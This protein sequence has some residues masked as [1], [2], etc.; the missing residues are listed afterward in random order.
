MSKYSNKQNTPLKTKKF[1]DARDRGDYS[2]KRSTMPARQ[3]DGQ[4]YAG[5][6]RLRKAMKRLGAR[7]N[8]FAGMRD[9][10]G[11]TKPGSMK[12]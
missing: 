4:T 7:Q 8:E 11:Y 5:G 1:G 12:S 6:K 9:A 10:S 3:R 2:A